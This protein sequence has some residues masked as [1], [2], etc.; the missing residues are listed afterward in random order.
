MSFKL[1]LILARCN[2]P[3]ISYLSETQK[4]NFQLLNNSLL[5]WRRAYQYFPI[6]LWSFRY[7]GG[8]SG[9]SS[10]SGKSRDRIRS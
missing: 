10:L 9:N 4:N 5:N 1:H 6:I 2:F 3:D 8:L 7:F